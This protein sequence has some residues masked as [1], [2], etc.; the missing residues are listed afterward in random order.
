[1]TEPTRSFEPTPERSFDE[2]LRQ[3]E[4]EKRADA[5]YY[6][7]LFPGNRFNDDAFSAWLA[8][9][10]E[11]ENVED[12]RGDDPTRPEGA[13]SATLDEIGP[14]RTKWRE[15]V[16]QRRTKAERER[17]EDKQAAKRRK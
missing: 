1:M 17:D 4:E 16:E 13:R 3:A 14:F 15:E 7:T 11:S 2:Y 9:L 6:N 8:A 5:P 10:P 12:R